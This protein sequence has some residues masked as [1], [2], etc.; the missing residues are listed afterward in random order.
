MAKHKIQKRSFTL[1]DIEI[2]AEGEGGGRTLTGYAALFD[3]PSQD[4]GGFIEIIRRGAFAKTIQESDIRA[5][6]NHDDNFVLGRSK[7]KTLRLEED[8]KGLK[9][10]IDIPDA[11]WALDLA[12][13]IARGDVD[14]MSFAFRTIRDAWTW[15]ESG[16]PD[17]RELLEVRLYDVSPVTYPAYEETEISVRELRARGEVDIPDESDED[18]PEKSGDGKPPTNPSAPPPAGHPDKKRRSSIAEMRR[19]LQLAARI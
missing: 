13:T 6:W 2:R 3:T 16:N 1:R 5:L 15:T 17:I 12:E 18:D 9:V 14:Q 7:T 4:L 19:R 8:D 10:E 11:Q